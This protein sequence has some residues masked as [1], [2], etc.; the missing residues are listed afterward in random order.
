M[1]RCTAIENICKRSGRAC[2]WGILTASTCTPCQERLRKLRCFFLMTGVVPQRRSNGSIVL[3]SI[4]RHQPE[5]DEG[6][7][8][9]RVTEG[10]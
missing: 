3:L 7:S 9:L 8:L 4:Y 6:V 1:I 2:I 10:K 5:G